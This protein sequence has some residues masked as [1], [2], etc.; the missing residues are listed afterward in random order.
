LVLVGQFVGSEASE[1]QAAQ[2]PQ[3]ASL[4]AAEGRAPSA[5]AV[6]SGRS[7]AQRTHNASRLNAVPLDD[8]LGEV[9]ADRKSRG[10]NHSA[11][12]TDSV[13]RKQRARS[14]G[15]ATSSAPSP[16]T[17]KRPKSKDQIDFG[18]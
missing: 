8:V 13:R 15:S 1:E 12:L 4:I 14:T 6:E 5:G 7:L 3:G 2:A 10:A 16:T 11:A 9:E 18:F 17:K